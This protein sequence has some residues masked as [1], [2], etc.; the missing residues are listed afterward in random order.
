MNKLFSHLP[1]FNDW[2]LLILRLAVGGAMLTHGWAKLS[3]FGEKAPEFMNFLGLGGTTS[4]A[5][6]VF[7]EFLCSILLILGLFTRLATI[8]L[9]ITMKVAIFMVHWQD[10][11]GEFELAFLYL[12]IY[13]ALFFSGAGAYSVDAL[14]HKKR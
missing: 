4:L 10:G 7:A 14:L 13:A 9:I 8:P 5:L 1:F 12:A 11:F 6:V 3:H 2:G